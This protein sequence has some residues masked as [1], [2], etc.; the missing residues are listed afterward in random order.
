MIDDGIN[1][2]CGL[3]RLSVTNDQ[4]AL[5]TS[6][7]H[8]C[9][10]RLQTRLHGLRNRFAPDHAG[11]D[12]FNFVSQLGIDRALAVNRMPKRINDAAKQFRTDGYLKNAPSRL[13]RVAFGN[14]VVFTENHCAH[15][16]A[17]EVECHAE[18]PSREFEHLALH[19]IG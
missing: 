4:L 13:D 3:A 1:R 10:N 18:G 5:T 11:S 16:V 12:F 14:L 15:R 19:G 8:H 2:Y 6:N 17:L 9:V 7:W